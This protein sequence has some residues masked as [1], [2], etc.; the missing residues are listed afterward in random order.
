MTTEQTISF[1]T[2]EIKVRTESVELLPFYATEGAA[3]A[4]LKANVKEPVVLAPHSVTLVPTGLFFEIP[5]GFEVQ[6]RPRSGLAA[7]SAVTVLNSPG[8]ID[9]DY[10]GEVQ[11]ILINHGTKEFVITPGMRIA[12]MVIAPVIQA[13]FSL[14]ADLSATARG[15]GGFGHSGM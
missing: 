4:D 10:R 7:K 6:I 3:G 2:I 13:K 1:E 14:I 8:T 9:S 15:T 5:P 12:Q 11:V